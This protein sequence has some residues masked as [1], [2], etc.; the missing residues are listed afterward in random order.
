MRFKEAAESRSIYR[1]SLRNSPCLVVLFFLLAGCASRNITIPVIGQENAAVVAAFNEMRAAQAECS[2]C[3]DTELEVEI[4]APGIIGRRPG[5]IHGYLQAK[6]PSF[7]KFVGINPLGQPLLIM[8]TNGKDF[9]SIVV[10]DAKVFE[11]G[12]DS[13]KF[14]KFCPPGFSPTYGY[15]WLT[16]RLRPGLADIVDVRR[17]KDV[18]G[19]WFDLHLEREELVDRVLFDPDERVVKRHI[20]QNGRGRVLLDVSYNYHRNSPLITGEGEWC[21]L[22]AQITVSSLPYNGKMILSFGEIFPG[23]VFSEEDFEIEFPAGF[24]LEMVE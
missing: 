19:Y 2:C 9:R 7:L 23:A 3:L 15:Y 18:P 14:K 6:S 5:I 16:G 11:G 21:P 10:P 24:E 13:A 8:A 12:V 17:Q 20:I 4:T 22:P 1:T